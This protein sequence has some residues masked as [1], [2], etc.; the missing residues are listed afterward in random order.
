MDKEPKSLG[1]PV[2]FAGGVSVCA[3]LV[4]LDSKP[5]S[6]AIRPVYWQKMPQMPC[7]NSKVSGL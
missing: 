5:T 3:P 7:N 1:S 2:L 4:L 6:P